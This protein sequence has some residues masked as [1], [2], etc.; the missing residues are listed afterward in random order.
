MAE[1]AL[2]EGLCTIENFIKRLDN[3]NM[4]VNVSDL[5]QEQEEDFYERENNHKE[6]Q[7]NERIII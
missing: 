5:D 6:K 2:K 1:K 4:I 3:R 7:Q